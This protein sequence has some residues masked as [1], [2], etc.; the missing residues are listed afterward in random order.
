MT[1]A[2]LTVVSHD[3]LT[4]HD[5]NAQ[6]LDRKRAKSIV[7]DSLLIRYLEPL[8]PVKEWPNPL[9]RHLD[10]V[11]QTR[12]ET[13][14]VIMR[15]YDAES[16]ADAALIAARHDPALDSNLVARLRHIVDAYVADMRISLNR[17]DT[18]HVEGVVV[19]VISTP[20]RN[21]IVEHHGL[22]HVNYAGL[23][24]EGGDWSE[25]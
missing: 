25:L 19:D 15:T 17:H 4:I 8:D 12:D 18:E 13:L 23:Y 21:H 22:A 9:A 10:I 1:D 20:E 3:A 7:A 6:R 16:D 11:A 5:S 14:L 2:F 24:D